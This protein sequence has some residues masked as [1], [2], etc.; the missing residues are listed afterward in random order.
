MADAPLFV[1]HFIWISR[2]FPIDNLWSDSCARIMIIANIMMLSLIIQFST[3]QIN[4]FLIEN[5][6]IEICVIWIDER[7]RFACLVSFRATL[8]TVF[9]RVNRSVGDWPSLWIYGCSQS[10]RNRVDRIFV[11]RLGD[12]C[13]WLRFSPAISR[14]IVWREMTSGLD[15]DT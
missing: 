3:S 1:R 7:W 8:I 2:F 15:I 11:S 14:I 10:N 6:N 4:D 13:G 9:F 12:E 5:L